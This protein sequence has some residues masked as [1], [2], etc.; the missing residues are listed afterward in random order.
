M[1][2][3]PSTHCAEGA[4]RLHGL[5]SVW[6]QSVCT[7]RDSF[8]KSLRKFSPGNP[9]LMGAACGGS[10]HALIMAISGGHSDTSC[11]REQEVCIEPQSCKSLALSSTHS[12]PHWSGG[13]L[14][15]VCLVVSM[16]CLL[17]C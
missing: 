3:V 4:S 7:R 8:E 15:T 6:E 2:N 17:L 13:N 10:L 11:G 5:I 1:F 16:G 12:I 14:S 9:E